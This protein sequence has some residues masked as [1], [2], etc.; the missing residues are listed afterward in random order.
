VTQLALD[1]MPERLYPAAPARL[2]TYLDCPRRYR[3]G[4][5][6]RPA[7]PRG[8]PWAHTSVGASVH[9]A[10]ARWWGLPRERRTPAE[11]GRLL[12][13][14]WLGGGFRDADQSG[15]SLQ[16]ARVEVERYLADVDPDEVPAGV[17]R[18]VSVRTPHASLWGRVDRIDDRGAEGLAVVDYKT[19]RSEPT[20]ADARD[21]LALAVY[22]AGVARLLRR[23]CTRVELHHL[24]SGRV[25]GFDHTEA[26][27]TEHLERA[28][29]VAAEL[30]ALDEAHGAGMSPEQADAAF[31]ARV[32][33]RCGWCEVRGSCPPGRAVPA[34]SAWA[35]V[36][37]LP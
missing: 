3:L 14:C 17:E 20:E 18:T 27:L 22:A 11:G 10:L 30:S 31:P 24:P 15:E 19:G 16:R 34:R 35:A 26:S 13:T 7:P 2:G 23:P 4:Y 29:A 36:P 21:S 6:D 33:P 1:G 12:V 5:L 8:G 28:D 25:V 32:A 9:T 37:D